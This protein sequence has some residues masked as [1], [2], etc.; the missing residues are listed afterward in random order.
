MEHTKKCHTKQTL[1]RNEKACHR[2]GENV[3]LEST[4]LIEDSWPKHTKN[5]VKVNNK[6]TNSPI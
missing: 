4:Y 5:A 1:G 2:P 3:F 6:K